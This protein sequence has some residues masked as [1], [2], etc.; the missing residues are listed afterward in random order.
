[1]NNKFTYFSL[2][3][4]FLL[5]LACKMQ[6]A[7][8]VFIQNNNDYSILVSI[9]TNNLVNEYEINAMQKL[10]TLRFFSDI[11]LEDGTWEIEIKNKINNSTQQYQHGKYFYGEL[12]NYFSI[13]TKGS[14]VEFSVDD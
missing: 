5:F 1:M 9:K 10:D 13:K 8:K 6:K 2:L 3:F 7:T 11:V 14:Y 4:V 12:S